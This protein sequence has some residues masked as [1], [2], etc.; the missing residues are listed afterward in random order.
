MALTAY[1]T[2]TAALLQAPSSPIP[3]IATGTL[4]SYINIARNQVAAE[5]ECIRVPATLALVNGTQNYN[6]S[7]ISVSGA[8]TNGIGS[9]ITVRSMRIGGQPLDIRSWEWFSQYYLGDGQAGTP[10]R[11]SQQGQSLLGTL[12]FDPTPNAAATASLDVVCLPIALVSDGTTEA[13]PPLW[14]DAIPFY[15]AWLAMQSLQRQADAEM[16]LRRYAS[17]VRRG[18]QF[19]TPTELPD[20]LPG[21]SGA[22]AAA[23]RQILSQPAEPQGQR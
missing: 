15:A 14:T 3:L 11:V 23:S 17:L 22:A 4:D 21:G 8:P 20:N 10:V 16:M 19:A 1:E 9:V 18:R 13:I 6:F 12:W 7:A 2:L 5:A